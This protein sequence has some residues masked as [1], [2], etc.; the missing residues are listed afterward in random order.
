MGMSLTKLKPRVLLLS[1]TQHKLMLEI[2]K[3]HPYFYSAMQ[4]T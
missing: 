3:L 1:P 2:P 4:E